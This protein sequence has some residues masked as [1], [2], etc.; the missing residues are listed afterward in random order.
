[1]SISD[2]RLNFMK[3]I[4]AFDGRIDK[5][6]AEFQKYCRGEIYR[7]PGWERLEAELIAFSSRQIFELVMQKNL[8]RVLYK[9]QTRKKIW[10]RWVD[11][12][13]RGVSQK[14]EEE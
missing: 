6:H 1:M 10:L 11:E 9:F 2:E 5:M 13:Q 14:E 3:A 8:D 4:T 12:F 7:L